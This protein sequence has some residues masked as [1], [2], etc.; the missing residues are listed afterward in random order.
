MHTMN[1]ENDAVSVDY[2]FD[3]YAKLFKIR[4]PQRRYKWGGIQVRAFWDD[5]NNA[6]S[7]SEPL[8]FLGSLL[9]QP[10]DTEG[11][12]VIDG[13]QRL[14]TVSMLIALLRDQLTSHA[15]VISTDDP[16]TA[17]GLQTRATR[18]QNYVQRT[19]LDGNPTGAT[20]LELNPGDETEF[21]ELVCSLGSTNAVPSSSSRHLVAGALRNLHKSLTDSL[22]Q[23]SQDEATEYLKALDTYLHDSLKFL[24]IEVKDQ[25]QAS[26]IFDTTNTRGLTLSL[27]EQIKAALVGRSRHNIQAVSRLID[28][29]DQVG[30]K[31]ESNGLA[32][33]A[34]DEYLRSIAIIESGLL[35]N[36]H[37]ILERAVAM[38]PENL[39]TAMNRYSA[40]FICIMNPAATDPLSDDLEDL[41][42]RFKNAQAIPLLISV[43]WKDKAHLAA[44]VDRALTIQVRNITIG[45]IQANQYQNHWPRWAKEANTKPVNEIVTEMNSV[46]I[47]DA[48][49]K[50]KFENATVRSAA[51]SF[52]ILRKLNSGPVQL[53]SASLDLEH[54]MP[55]SLVRVLPE[56]ARPNGNVL[57]WCATLGVHSPLSNDDHS[58]LTGV[59]HRLGNHTLL[60]KG[61]NRAAKD[62]GFDVK[63]P[64]FTSDHEIT[65]TKQLG[66]YATWSEV[67]INHRQEKMANAAVSVWGK[68]T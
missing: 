4:P 32:L 7:G 13:Q 39:R 64:F 18:L 62:A 31:F 38:G 30:S 43:L 58:R 17:A 34:M 59:I 49:F 23:M 22:G 61:K 28:T 52:G 8:Y 48:E 26:L 27:S 15:A 51:Q 6:I 14:T 19:D 24:V 42:T 44:V 45:Q 47:E 16:T 21:V 11:M 2:L 37:S 1:L 35:L 56:G 40:S 46:L 3:G 67:Q 68:P 66:E 41:I 9:L 50:G 60:E 29:W 33:N 54:V 12:S 10:I 36:A 5:I 55:K 57:G 25:Y 65:W 20:V 63:L 53:K